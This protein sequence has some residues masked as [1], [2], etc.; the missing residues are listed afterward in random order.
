[1]CRFVFSSKSTVHLYH[2]D[3]SLAPSAPPGK[4][5]T[6]GELKDIQQALRWGPPAEI[7]EIFMQTGGFSKGILP[8]KVLDPGLGLR[9]PITKPDAAGQKPNMWNEMWELSNFSSKSDS[10]FCGSRLVH[11]D[12]NWLKTR[13]YVDEISRNLKLNDFLKIHK[14]RIC[15]KHLGFEGFIKGPQRGEHFCESYNHLAVEGQ[16]FG[17]MRK[18]STQTKKRH[19]GKGFLT[20]ST[21]T[22]IRNKCSVHWFLNIN[23][24]GLFQM[25]QCHFFRNHLLLV[26][27]FKTNELF[28]S[29]FSHDLMLASCG[30]RSGRVANWI[31]L[32]KVYL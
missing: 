19:F 17:T 31:F 27:R 20:I 3:G 4:A 30:G 15:R 24:I 9:A 2:V 29:N 23:G 28:T 5:A 16:S 25:Y 12:V 18:W 10:R 13:I 22:Y 1:M 7:W 11:Q 8:E 6:R 26:I 21:T 32:F 14:Q